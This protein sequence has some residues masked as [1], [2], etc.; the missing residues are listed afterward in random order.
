MG[1]VKI[2]RTTDD[3]MKNTKT[4]AEIFGIVVQLTPLVK[5]K[6]MHDGVTFHIEFPTSSNNKH[7]KVG[8]EVEMELNLM[9]E[10][11]LK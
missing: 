6:Y 11:E 10:S 5:V 9:V 7:L 1:C 4:G 2:E 3:V 8:D